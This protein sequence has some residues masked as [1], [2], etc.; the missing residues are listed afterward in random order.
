MRR[1]LVW[2]QLGPISMVLPLLI[3]L[4][5]YPVTIAT[6]AS[7][8]GDRHLSGDAI[9]A[10][11]PQLNANESRA[12]LIKSQVLLDRLGY[13]PGVIDG[14]DGE[15][16]RKAIAEFQSRHQIESTG[17]LDRDT[18]ERLASASSEPVIADYEISPQDVN[19]PFE[20]HI[21]AT[22]E[23]MAR[24][25]RLSY[26]DPRQELAEKFHMTE[27]LLSELNPGIDFHRAGALIKVANP[28]RPPPA[29]KAV[30]IVIDK[31]RRSLLAFD[32]SDNLVG[33]Y[34]ASI[35]SKEKPAPSGVFKVA[36]VARNPTYTYNPKFAFKEIQTKRRLTIR[37]GPNNPVG[38]VWIELTAPS[39]GI[40]GTSAP[41]RIGKTESHGCVRLTNWDAL[42]LASMVSH[43]TVVDFPG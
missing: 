31:P 9:G 18:Y 35:G 7:P 13:S 16:F 28:A 34:P 30:K 39:Y 26:R 6:A 42:D 19:G 32:A 25:P 3:L 36:D 2:L 43:S 20:P 33:F 5:A 23:G 27:A 14:R 29:K 22:F 10:A 37:P 12:L 21:P 41:E 24:L 38:L 17:K 1:E 40:H 11:R 15:N 8:P 4:L